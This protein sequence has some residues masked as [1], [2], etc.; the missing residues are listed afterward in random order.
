MGEVADGTSSEA[1]E[2][3]G[4]S[5][6]SA[7]SAAGAG[8]TAP[9][10]RRRALIALTALISIFLGYALVQPFVPALS[11]PAVVGARIA[12]TVAFFALAWT[13]ERLERALW[14]TVIF[15][16]VTLIVR[17]AIQALLSSRIGVLREWHTSEVLLDYSY[18]VCLLAAA[19]VW[20]SWKRKRSR[21][22]T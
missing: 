9:E 20:V 1:K 13:V 5:V 22:D 17:I 11:V 15:F 7:G 19:A 10:T 8:L 16:V 2:E 4:K 21:H 3:T 14:A 6:D 12:Y 18:P